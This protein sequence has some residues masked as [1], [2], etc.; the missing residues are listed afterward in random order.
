MKLFIL[1]VIFL[2][3]GIVI[4]ILAINASLGTTRD[5]EAS[6]FLGCVGGFF[7]TQ[8]INMFYSLM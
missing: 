3:V 8:S 5:I 6:P 4:L 1:S 7:I 2:V